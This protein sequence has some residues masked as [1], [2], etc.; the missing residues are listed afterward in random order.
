MRRGQ[1]R[2]KLAR[3]S[4]KLSGRR[5]RTG[6]ARWRTAQRGMCN[7]RPLKRSPWSGRACRCT[8]PKLQDVSPACLHEARV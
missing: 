3:N 6:D 2:R 7:S 1:Q 8:R 5:R 4:G